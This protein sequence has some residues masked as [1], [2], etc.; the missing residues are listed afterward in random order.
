VTWLEQLGLI[1][2]AS[3]LDEICGAGAPE[4][5][6]PVFVPALAGLGAPY[7]A[8][9]ARGAWTSLSLAS[10]R[11][12]LVRAVIWGIAAQVAI[13]ARAMCEDAGVPLDRLRVDGGLSRSASLLQAQAD[14]MQAPVE[15]Y[16]SAD[17][18]ALGIAAFARIGAGGA[19]SPQEAVG[20][21]EP[22][23]VFEPRMGADEAAD[24]LGDFQATASAL[25]DLAGE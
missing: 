1:G 20:R 24:R 16:P 6:S 12:D 5:G 10:G 9:Q 13:L 15:R 8:P 14:L 22:E 25:I 2:G 21:W 19:S 17:A 23:A 3:E 11:E 18:T 4:N 7:W